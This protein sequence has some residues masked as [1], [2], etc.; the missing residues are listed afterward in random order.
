[1]SANNIINNRKKYLASSFSLSYDEPLHIIRGKGQY[2]YDSSGEEYVD[3][4]NNIA[5]VGHCHPRVVETANI[6]NKLLN[7]NTRYL[8]NSVLNYAKN[9][10]STLTS[11]RVILLQ[12]FVMAC[13]SVG[14]IWNWSRQNVS[15][16]ILNRC[17]NCV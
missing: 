12:T 2:L 4:V 17:S 7:T 11:E 16:L 9:L 6:Q 1:M 14:E 15:L 8:H 3:A 10:S 5:H 13:L